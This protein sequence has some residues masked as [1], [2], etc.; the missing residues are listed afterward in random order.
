LCDYVDV[1]DNDVVEVDDDGDTHHG[2]DDKSYI[3]RRSIA[4]MLV[5]DF[6]MSVRLCFICHYVLKTQQED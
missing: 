4:K 3:A 6:S 1:C 2:G 5:A